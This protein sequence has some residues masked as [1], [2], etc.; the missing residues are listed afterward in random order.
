MFYIDYGD[1][2]YVENAGLCFCNSSFQ[3]Y[4][5]MKG[6]M[7]KNKKVK[8]QLHIRRCHVCGALNESEQHVVERCESCHKALL[9]FLF[10]ESTYDEQI[11]EMSKS[12]YINNGKDLKI[13]Y[14][15]LVGIA[16]YW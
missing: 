8:A 5:K 14:P 2:F 15:P 9:P 13:V 12:V 11:L 6:R 4:N 7:K 1:V 3:I 10:C 16:L